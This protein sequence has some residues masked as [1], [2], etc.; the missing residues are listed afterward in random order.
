[1]NRDCH[2]DSETLNAAA[3]WH[4]KLTSRPRLADKVAFEAWRTADPA[5][6]SAYTL[7]EQGWNKTRSLRDHPEIITLRQETLARIASQHTKRRYTLGAAGMAAVIML[8][9][10]TIF[11]MQSPTEWAENKQFVSAE[12]D[13]Q[14][15]H[16][17]QTKV[18]ERRNITLA[19]GSKIHLDTNSIV[20]VRYTPHARHIILENGQALFDVAKSPQRPFSV[21]VG[22]RIVTAYGTS[23]NIRRDGKA[24]SVSLVQGSVGVQTR[25]TAQ[26][27]S[28]TMQPNERLVA[29]GNHISVTRYENLDQFLN[30]KAGIIHFDNAPMTDAVHELNRYLDTPIRLADAKV[31]AI[32]VSGSFPTG[33]NASF[34]EAVQFSFPI[35]VNRGPN[36]DVV[37]HYRD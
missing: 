8:A 31:A 7:I 3:R 21:I 25:G 18:G 14:P 33:S 19:D 11:W 26:S 17:I 13:N 30:W 35:A 34:L 5:H 9:C 24:M 23:F 32:R 16:I 37:L 29:N 1:M 27:A 6:A 10:G 36:G 20:R 28:V 12:T 15:F 22:E 2:I 4:E